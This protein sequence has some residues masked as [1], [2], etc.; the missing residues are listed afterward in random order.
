MVPLAAPGTRSTRGSTVEGLVSPKMS[1]VASSL[2]SGNSLPALP[3]T[4][5]ALGALKARKK[6]MQ[7]QPPTS[8][9][10]TA[11]GDFDGVIYQSRIKAPKAYETS[12]VK[13]RWLL[14]AVRTVHTA[15]ALLSNNSLSG[16]GNAYKHLHNAEAR[17]RCAESLYKLSKQP[18]SELMIIQS[19]AIQNIAD[20]T[21]VEDTHLAH[22]C[23][24]TLANLTSTT[25]DETLGAFIAKKGIP[26]VLEISWSPSYDVKCLCALTLCRLSIAPAFAKFL[27]SSKAIIELATMLSLPYAPLQQ[28]CVQ[29]L[30]N[31]IAH[32]CEFPEKLFA[33]GG[34]NAHTNL[35]V[36]L[37]LSQLVQDPKHGP[38]AAAVIYNMSLQPSSASGAVRGSVGELLYT[39][40]HAPHVHL[41]NRSR[42]QTVQ[43]IKDIVLHDE[44][45]G[46]SRLLTRALGHFSKYL[47]LHLL[48]GAW[49]LKA[50]LYLLSLYESMR[51][52]HADVFDFIL[53]PAS[54][55]L[56][57][58]SANDEFVKIVLSE[59]EPL[60]KRTV[61]LFKWAASN[62]ECAH[63]TIRTF[64]N[65][66]RN[67]RCTKV[68]VASNVVP[69]LNTALLLPPTT[70]HLPSLKEDALVALIN[71][72]C[73]QQ[74]PESCFALELDTSLA[75]S[76]EAHKAA[77]PAFGYAVAK[78]MCYWTFD[79]RL[80]AMVL[81]DMDFL[82]EALLFGFYFPLPQKAA[83]SDAF[84]SVKPRTASP[85]DA[86]DDDA[87]G[88]H[89]QLRFL[90]AM[91]YCAS[92]VRSTDHVRALVQV[93]LTSMATS[94]GAIEYYCAGILFALSRTL[95]WLFHN[96]DGGIEAEWAAVLYAA[97]IQD[98]ILR[99]SRSTLQ[100]QTTYTMGTQ[101]FCTSTL[102]HV[103]A[104]EHTSAQALAVLVEACNE[105]EDPAT[106]MACASTFAIVSFTAAGRDLL[107]TTH[108][109]AHALNK[110]GRASVCQQNAAIAACNVAI[111]GCIW[112][113]E[114]LK[115]FVVV[116]L[117][118]S[119]SSDAI[120]VHA[121]T[122]YNLL[123]HPTSR[124]QVI[125]EGVLY[126][127]L[128]LA[129]LQTN[130]LSGLEETLSLCLHALFNLSDHAGHHETLLKLGVTPF[131]FTGVS[132]RRKRMLHFLNVDSRRYAVGLLC[133]LSA[134][135][136]NHKELITNAQVV[137]ILR[138]L[139]DGDVETRASAA[140][141]VRNLTLHLGNAEVMCTRNLLSLLL[142]FMTSGHETVRRL[143][144]Q[145][146][147]NCSLVTELVHLFQQLNVADALL[148]VLHTPHL[149]TETAIAILKTLHNLALD[150]TLALHLLQ[151]QVV[152]RWQ[153]LPAA[154]WSKIELSAVAAATC[155]VLS[156]KPEGVGL[157]ASQRAVELCLV[158]CAGSLPTSSLVLDCLACLGHLSSHVGSHHILF[159]S[160]VVSAV[161]TLMETAR[162]LPPTPVAFAELYLCAT[163]LLRN[164]SLSA[165]VADALHHHHPHHHHH[166][167]LLQHVHRH[168]NAPLTP[169]ENAAA[170]S[171]L[172]NGLG[173]L[174]AMLHAFAA[175]ADEARYA[176]MCAEVCV[177][178]ANL[179]KLKRLRQGLLDLGVLQVLLDIHGRFGANPTYRFINQTCSV[180]LHRLAAEDSATMEPGLIEALLSGLDHADTAVHEGE[181]EEGKVSRLPHKTPAY[182][183]TSK[184]L[185]R[186]TYRDV[187]WVNYVV[188]VP[189]A[190]DV[191]WDLT[192]DPMAMSRIRGPL[193]AIQDVKDARCQV[194]CASE[195]D[196]SI[197]LGIDSD[198]KDIET[199]P[200]PVV[201]T[202]ESEEYGRTKPFDRHMKTNR[203]HSRQ[204]V[205]MM[206]ALP[207]L[208]RDA[209]SSSS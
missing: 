161:H 9:P 95:L 103:C 84:H 75:F 29:A 20:L 197:V 135:E 178:V 190:A 209:A 78:T 73:H 30:S 109:L 111:A 181:R 140:M 31:M 88:V 208:E 24:A 188:Q 120:Q 202:A 128:K 115:D 158:L 33:G 156:Q 93:I 38:F 58:L 146:L 104:S 176:R 43:S 151:T 102:Y 25:A 168:P 15:D 183:T 52:T 154:F 199:P 143:A 45:M 163:V 99:L 10:Q 203:R 155:R 26:V 172:M 164:L 130:G 66:T 61:D 150:D 97:P 148:I 67:A 41:Q 113:A 186:Q 134:R 23:A 207:Q 149:E 76:F 80:R 175:D 22:Y 65:L 71:I 53:A 152:A 157:V 72:A 206:M 187:R 193:P 110:L 125:E 40:V 100:T 34:S 185:C 170:S 169:A 69:V 8:R 118:R 2:S 51:S 4:D 167:V 60:V 50:T 191:T 1:V 13:E 205:L 21:D 54:R 36:I 74:M 182:L 85:L 121:K 179:T 32:G 86:F 136:A 16:A 46:I 201:A 106:L 17:A 42:L 105:S 138:A 12:S 70:P 49:S 124:H 77:S 89:A 18:L 129:Q 48:L 68:L 3:R 91:C 39:L 141:T 87:D 133:N 132:G 55:V 196:T 184:G 127:F 28:L 153:L 98:A 94:H 90:A 119:N 27:H 160:N 59:N 63:N 79:A 92:D 204:N 44:Q 144:A 159:A 6:M 117:L 126:S 14:A 47:D 142:V 177:A 5:P 64:A 194:E 11:A 35:G 145:A 123:S 56:A 83:A 173:W 82:M 189:N 116:A 107:L 114:E 37:A 171:Q 122:L 108:G 112:S 174:T 165:T 192:A 195:R 166:Q 139:C 162:P 180:T 81:G 131:L 200:L 62:D 198:K 101:A 147:G 57:N 96:D 7:K 137:D 19:G